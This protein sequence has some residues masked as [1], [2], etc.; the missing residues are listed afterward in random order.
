MRIRPFPIVRLTIRSR[1]AA[2][3]VWLAVMAAASAAR[4]QEISPVIAEY[5][6]E[7]RGKLVVANHTLHPLNVV[8]EAMSF[9]VD[10]EGRPVYAPLDSGVH[11]R[12]S[13][14]S[15][16]L[17]PKDAYVVFY[18]ASARQLP[19]WF[20]VYATMTGLVTSTGVQLALRLPHT[21]YLLAKQP[22]ARDSVA[23]VDARATDTAIVAEVANHSGAL[24]RVK[25]V[26]VRSGADKKIYPGFP[27][28]PRHRRTLR[29]DWD[30]AGSPDQVILRFE[31]FEVHSALVDTVR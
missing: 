20:T 30:R 8:L 17:G 26:E 1:A 24:A 29:L 16:R 11:I 3:A 6:G 19:A 22:L 15:F 4:A 28:F 25:E 9:T 10:A 23:L 2:V 7:G 21:V 18:E 12:L 27:L 31:K 13:A 14:R 5:H